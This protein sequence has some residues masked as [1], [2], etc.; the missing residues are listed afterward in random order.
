MS[1]AVKKTTKKKTARRPAAPLKTKRKKSTK[2]KVA[3]AIA[4]PKP[5]AR[6]SRKKSANQTAGEKDTNKRIDEAIAANVAKDAAAEVAGQKR[7]RSRAAGAAPKIMVQ[8]ATFAWKDEACIYELFALTRGEGFKVG[9]Q[10]VKGPAVAVRT[11]TRTGEHVVAYDVSDARLWEWIGRL[12]LAGTK[13]LAAH[14]QF[15]FGPE[16]DALVEECKAE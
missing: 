1:K 9:R 14:G 13:Y 16:M 3:R 2:K 12:A 4:V 11:L 6:R 8:K 10:V 15:V 7:P 5:R